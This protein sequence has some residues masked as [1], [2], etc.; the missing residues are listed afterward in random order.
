MVDLNEVDIL[1]VED[2][3]NDMLILEK[4]IKSLKHKDIR[5]ISA[6]TLTEAV[7]ILKKENLDLI[8]SDLTLP[9]SRGLE[10]FRILHANSPKIPVILLTGMDDESIATQAVREGAQDYLIK[11]EINAQLLLRTAVYAIERNALIQERLKLINELTGALS[12]IKFLSGLLPICA[13]C[14]KIRNDKG[15]WE[16]VESYLKEHSDIEFTH[17]LCPDCI[18]RIYPEY[19]EENNKK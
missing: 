16:Q 13:G 9:D 3:P 19:I 14:K 8:I 7:D 11:G 4:L 15:Y 18:G 1:L 17:G 2:N 6:A 10:T 5:F 12:K